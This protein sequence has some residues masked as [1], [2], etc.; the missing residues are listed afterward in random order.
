MI[1]IPIGK[2]YNSYII[3]TYNYDSVKQSIKN[4]A[5]LNGFD[6]TQVDTDNHPDIFFLEYPDSNIPIN[7]IRQDIIDSSIYSPK[8]ADKKIYVIYDAINLS[9]DAQNTMLKTLEEPP[10]FDVFFLVTSNVNA[11]LDTIKSRCVIIK[12]SADI[13]YKEILGLE[14]INE[15]LRLIANIKYESVSNK[16]NFAEN[17]IG[18]EN[19]LKKLIMVYRYIIRDA[20][21]YKL[22]LSK[23]DLYLKERE[24]DIISIA[25][26]LTIEELGKIVDGLDKLSDENKYNVNKKIALFNFFEC[27]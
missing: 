17:F 8:Y 21:F 26:S 11:L 18:T 12:D 24:D 22:T 19:S 3:E 6:R 9:Q 1:N 20:M 5:I 2:T 27:I 13:D 14:F 16:M 23:N 4:F 7:V 15:A 25:N 10:E